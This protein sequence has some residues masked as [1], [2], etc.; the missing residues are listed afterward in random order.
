MHI[1]QPNGDQPIQTMQICENR[2]TFL[3]KQSFVWPICLLETRNLF[4][5]FHPHHLIAIATL[6]CVCIIQYQPVLVC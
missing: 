1:L 3:A 6:F 5:H 4:A 2:S